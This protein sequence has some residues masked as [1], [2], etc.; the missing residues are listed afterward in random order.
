M[1][2]SIHIAGDIIETASVHQ[3]YYS[4]LHKRKGK[5]IINRPAFDKYR[6]NYW[7]SRK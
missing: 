2:K 5:S 1:G 3:I 6:Y 7:K 4:V